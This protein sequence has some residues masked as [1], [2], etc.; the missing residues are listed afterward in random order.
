MRHVPEEELHAYLDQA[1]SRSQCVEIETHL[2]R[3][4][5]C[6]DARDDAAALRDR[7]TAL[8]A[9]LTP[10]PLIIPPA[11]QQLASRQPLPDVSLWVRR[12]R[13]IG[14]WAA[15]V[16]AAVGVG[17]IARATAFPGPAEGALP[18]ATALP[19][20]AAPSPSL[21]PVVNDAPPSVTVEQKPVL[22]LAR[23]TPAEPVSPPT[24]EPAPIVQPV[25]SVLGREALGPSLASVEGRVVIG[26]STFDRLWRAVEWDEALSLAGGSLPLIEGLPVVGV[27]LQMGQAGERPAVI[28][29]QQDP[30]G[31]ILQTIE[32]PV[33]KVT[34]FL[35]R[36]TAPGV[37]TGEPARTAP[38]YLQG[39][40]GSWH[41]SLRALAV[42]GR[43]PTESLTTL[44]RSAALR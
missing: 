11:Y 39:A 42:T 19:A 36:P 3:C 16:A 13:R 32:G 17:W 41:R 9:S 15:G 28:V 31:E 2:A 5:S 4:A 8:L 27:L 12:Y 37:R 25:S 18:V 43:L 29:A 34:E 7:T 24:I 33:A 23:N 20:P 35:Q 1:L 22:Q 14:L 10:R 44:A 26:A 6:R 30:S 40:N 38:D 21:P